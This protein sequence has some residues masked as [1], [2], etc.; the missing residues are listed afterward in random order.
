VQTR[1]CLVSRTKKVTYIE[2]TMTYRCGIYM[3]MVDQ[4][5]CV[6]DIPRG[7]LASCLGMHLVITRRTLTNYDSVSIR[8]G[9]SVLR[10]G[11]V[12][13]LGSCMNSVLQKLELK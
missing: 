6:F 8:P 3:S 1:H 2:E 13:F 5:H 11:S 7:C 10:F 9:R 12:R 4:L